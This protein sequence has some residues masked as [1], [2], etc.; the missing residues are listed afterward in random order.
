MRSTISCA[1]ALAAGLFA[2]SVTA[3]FNAA[4]NS[5]VVVYWGQGKGNI[6]IEE[7]CDDETIDVVVLGFINKFPKRVGEY[8]GSDFGQ[9][10][11]LSHFTIPLTCMSGNACWAEWYPKPDGSGRSDLLSTCPTIGPGIKA[12]QAKGKK[13]LLSLGGATPADYYLPSPAVARYFA[14][15]LWGAFGPVTTAWTDADKP[16]PFGDAVVD[17]FDLDIESHMANPPFPEYQNANYGSFVA[18]LKNTL[19][20][21]GDKAFYISGAPQCPRPDTRKSIIFLRHALATDTG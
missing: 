4:G 8:P 21:N 12:C 20:P 6:P 11:M 16:R 1:L 7:V 17:G 2:S 18:H 10:M 19:F 15:F 9:S 14:E 13:V 3:D 5:N